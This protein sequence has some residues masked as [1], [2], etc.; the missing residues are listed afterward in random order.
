MASVHVCPSGMAKIAPR[1]PVLMTAI[2]M[3]NVLTAFVIA[4]QCSTGRVAR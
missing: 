1:C 3:A 2:S 4:F